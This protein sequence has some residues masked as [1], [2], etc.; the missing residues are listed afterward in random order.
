MYGYIITH[1]SIHSY[2][3]KDKNRKKYTLEAFCHKG[4]RAFIFSYGVKLTSTRR[5][6]GPDLA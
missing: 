6:G 2:T 3:K 5:P 1:N 4:F